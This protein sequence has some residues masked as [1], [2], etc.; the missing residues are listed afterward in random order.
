MSDNAPA[1]S[2]IFDVDYTRPSADHLKAVRASAAMM[3]LAGRVG[4][5]V[6][7]QY[8]S[9]AI[10]NVFSALQ[11]ALSSPLT[12][13]MADGW[14]HYR[15]FVKYC[16]S[17]RYPPD[18]IVQETLLEHTI[19]AQLKP[20]VRVLLDQVE[21]G[22]VNFEATIALKLSGGILTIQGGKFRKFQPGKCQ[23]TA[24]LKCEGA[25]LSEVKSRELRLPGELSFGDGVAIVPGLTH[26]AVTR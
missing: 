22:E 14:N 26:E 2:G 20:K 10:S 12:Q 24:S 15:P 5:S 25:V 11:R 3:G 6:P 9:S 23:V 17:K 7:V 19:N 4:P 8:W 13:L 16:D 21:V 1:V 18:A